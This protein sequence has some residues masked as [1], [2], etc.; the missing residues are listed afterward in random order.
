MLFMHGNRLQAEGR[1]QSKRGAADRL[2]DNYRHSI[3]P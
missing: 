3:P 1:L 2:C